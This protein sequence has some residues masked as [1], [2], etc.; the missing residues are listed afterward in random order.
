MLEV[1]CGDGVILGQLAASGKQV[2]GVDTDETALRFARQHFRTQGLHGLFTQT[3]PPG[4]FDTIIMAEVIEHLDDARDVLDE[5]VLHLTPDGRLLLTTPIKLLEHSPDAL[6]VHEY[7]PDELTTFLG[8]Y[9]HHV[10]L[11]TM[12]PV[13]ALDWLCRRPVRIAANLLYALTGYEWLDHVTSPLGVYWTQ[14]I[15]ATGPKR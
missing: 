2:V 3:I 9:F 6:H 14:A 5:L 12:H 10:T 11:T 4:Y 15:V 1:G 13:W 8:T 7:Q